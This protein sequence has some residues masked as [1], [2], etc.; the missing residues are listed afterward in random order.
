MGVS[1]ENEKGKRLGENTELLQREKTTD[2]DI[3]PQAEEKAEIR[4]HKF[5]S[6]T[7]LHGLREFLQNDKQSHIGSGRENDWLNFKV[8][9][10]QLD[11][12]VN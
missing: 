5:V 11:A 10:C 12:G 8:A 3:Q 9:A 4:C 1:A 6:G 7:P 2:I